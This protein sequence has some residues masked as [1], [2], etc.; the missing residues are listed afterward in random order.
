MEQIRVELNNLNANKNF[1]QLGF[2][3]SRMYSCENLNSPLS[4]NLQSIPE[5]VI[6]LDIEFGGQTLDQHLLFQI[7]NFCW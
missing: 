6:N 3:L 2:L 4:R 1:V 7:V 5:E